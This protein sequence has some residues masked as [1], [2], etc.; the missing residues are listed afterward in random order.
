MKP[1][2]RP[3]CPQAGGGTALSSCSVHPAGLVSQ[4]QPHM[5]PRTFTKAAHLSQLPGGP[6]RLQGLQEQ[7]QVLA[8]GDRAGLWRGC[9]RWGVPP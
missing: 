5:T 6:Q 9:V 7:A 1:S 4:P 8:W 3:R 2:R